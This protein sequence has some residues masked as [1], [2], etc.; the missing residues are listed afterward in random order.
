MPTSSA[1]GSR[2]AALRAPSGWV[3]RDL[4][5]QGLNAAVDWSKWYVTDEEDLGECSLHK[6]I[7]ELLLSCIRE[8]GRERRCKNALISADAFFSW[9]K[10]HLLVRVSPDVYPLD[11]PPADMRVGNWQPWK[12]GVRPPR[13][14]LEVVSLDW[15]NDHEDARAICA[16][17]LPRIGHFRS[18]GSRE[19]ARIT[20]YPDGLPKA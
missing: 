9:V 10:E 8:L 15:K 20:P 4:S 1:S 6:Q 17:R 18:D 14:A 2:R 3:I 16:A 7:I 5:S 13:F 12:R 19:S 11:D